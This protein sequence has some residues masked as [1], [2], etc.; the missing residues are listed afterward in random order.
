[1]TTRLLIVENLHLERE[2][3]EILRGV[4]LTVARGQIFGLLGRNGSG[5]STLAYTLMGCA[6]YT[7][8]AGRILFDGQD[9]TRRSV[10]ERARLGLTLAW[11][12]PARFEG[13]KVQDYLSLG[14]K[15]PSQKRIEE[16]LTAVALPPRTY[17]KRPVDDTLSGGE[18][19]R[20]ELAAVYAMRPRLAVLDEPDSG[21]DVLS[22]SDIARL[23][24][25]MASEG[26]AVLL[27]THRD[28]MVPVAD[29]AALMCEGEIVQVGDPQAVREYYMR[30]C[31]P[32]EIAQPVEAGR[33][34]ER[35]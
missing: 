19:K 32:C 20:I 24:R 17:L 6:G 5:K 29:V 25:R 12:E 11:Q 28:E 14:M 16:A 3:K 35:L 26:T 9:I 23:I 4:N 1:M 2:G 18:R 8:S 30:R 34:Y 15:E 27:I 13:L 7:P 10:T 21:I 31:K 33:E 22:L